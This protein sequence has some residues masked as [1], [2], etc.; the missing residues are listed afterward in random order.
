[1]ASLFSHAVAACALA[2]G[3]PERQRTSWRFWYLA[4]LC[5]IVPDVDVAG[6]ALGVRYE[7]LW[8]HRGMTHSLLFAVLLGAAAAARLRPGWNKEGLRLAALMIAITASRGIRDA[9]TNGG[10][11]IA[12]FAPFDASRY[13]F[14]WTPV[15]V[16]PIGAAGFLSM[17]GVAVL[18]SEIVW[19]WLPALA[20]GIVLRILALRR[21][22]A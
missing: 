21:R 12:F 13:F 9:F 11:G 2:Q 20:V 19:I 7:D 18:K 4:V 1:M 8:G 15:E 14:P 6:F 16:S 10:L 17:R 5:A 22:T 3:A